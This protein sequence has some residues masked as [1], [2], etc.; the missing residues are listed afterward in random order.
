MNKTLLTESKK[1]SVQDIRI[2]VYNNRYKYLLGCGLLIMYFCN[3]RIQ[4]DAFFYGSTPAYS[5]SF[6]DMCIYLFKGKLF[7]TSDARMRYEIPF[8]W[9]SEQM[10]ALYIV[11][12]YAHDTRT[13]IGQQYLIRTQYTLSWLIGK[14]VYVIASLFIFYF[15]LFL[16]TFCVTVP[17][18]HEIFTLHPDLI[19]MT[20][21][22]HIV[23]HTLLDLYR[24]VFILPFL[25]SVTLGIGMVVL[26][27]IVKPVYAYVVLFVYLIASDFYLSYFLIGNYS[28]LIRNI[29]E[30]RMDSSCTFINPSIAIGIEFAL[31][32]L[33][34]CIGNAV[35][36]K[37]DYLERE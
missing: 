12:S 11:G 27:L 29:Q 9:L 18:S 26:Q 23:N 14:F 4:I 37:Y 5:P 30:N 3:Y 24:G 21:N 31:I 13:K 1:L 8:M 33:F 17:F 6:M 7:F 28:M 15:I 16:F 32:I 36:K 25:T 22:I 2:G 20:S 35:L 10:Y 34:V 19:A